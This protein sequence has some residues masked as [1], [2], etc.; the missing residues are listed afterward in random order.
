MQTES[1][2][3]SGMVGYCLLA[4][5]N[6]YAEFISMSSSDLPEAAQ[7][8]AMQPKVQLLHPRHGL[9]LAHAEAQPWQYTHALTAA[10]STCVPTSIGVAGRHKVILHRMPAL[11]LCQSI[12]VLSLRVAE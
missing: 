1:L 6:A 10:C 5:V 4:L 9:H 8:Q 7:L 2:Q 11:A 3:H 12:P